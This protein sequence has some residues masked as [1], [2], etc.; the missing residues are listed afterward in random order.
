MRK[1]LKTLYAPLLLLSSFFLLFLI[2]ITYSEI[3]H[4][5]ERTPFKSEAAVQI[6]ESKHF[7][8]TDIKPYLE[9]RGITI[10]FS[11]PCYHENLR[12]KL[13]IFPPVRLN[14]HSNATSQKQK[15]FNI[16][17]EFKAGQNY[18]ISIS[19]DFSCGGLAYL[20]TLNT[21]KMPDK[22][23]GIE[24]IEKGS[25]I[26]K[27]S[28]Q[29]LHLDLVNIDELLF[30]GL[31]IPPILIPLTIDSVSGLSYEKIKATYEERLRT[32]M[33]ILDKGPG[34]KE[35]AGAIIE[36]R[37][38]FFPGME[39][40]T[41]KTFSMPLSF[42][43][44]KERGGI[45]VVSLKSNRAEQHIESPVRI[46]RITDI[47]L[48]YK[49][50]DNSLLIF[51]SSL[52]TGKPLKD[53]SLLALF[54]RS[55]A[56]NLG[57]TDKNGV[58]TL[59]NLNAKKPILLDPNDKTANSPL[60]FNDL[61]FIL[62]I[63]SG[64]SSFIEINP[65][66]HI[67]PDWVTQSH[68]KKAVNRPLKGHVF[69]ERGIYRPGET[70]H[71]KGTIREYK[72][73]AILPPMD[74]KPTIKI[75]DSKG[76]IV[77]EG[78]IELSEFGTAS[79]SLTIKPYFPLGTYTLTM[80]FAG[81]EEGAD[82][83]TASRTFQVQEFQ[84]PRHFTEI[85]FKPERKKDT[86]YINLDRETAFLGCEIGGAYYAGGP[87]KHG[88][89][90]WKIYYNSTD[91][92]KEQYKG[93]TFGNPLE[94]R[95]ELIESGESILDENG[96]IT[97]NVP[98]SKNVV[99]GLY[100]VEVIATVVDFD[101][102]A[103]SEST[104]Y[105]AE[106]GYLVGISSHKG[107][108]KAGDSESLT[109][110]VIDKDGKHL[111]KGKISVEVMK[112][113][114][115]WIR[116]RN[117]FGNVYWGGQELWRKELASTIA[118]EKSNAIFDFDFVNGGDYLLK[119]TYQGGDGKSYTSSTRY[120]VEGYFYGYE[121]ENR[122]RNFER[123][124]VSTEKDEYRPGETIRVLV[125]PHKK[126]SSLLMTIEREGV[127]EHRTIDGVGGRRYI[128]IPVKKDLCTEHLYIIP[129]NYCQRRIPCQ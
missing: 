121:Y 54:G 129:W 40:N 81:N 15:I 7:T 104:V 92:P 29:M 105:Q 87:V 30:Q 50:S 61:R 34:L 76:E 86:R 1:R 123:L 43:K 10:T 23:S 75:V 12:H 71:Y 41:K 99:S 79:G 57:R 115:T 60:S 28:R 108:I 82:K 113:G 117:E 84:P 127:I 114:F 4:A 51:A 103:A 44:E 58:L 97:V 37:Q 83:G 119:F 31:S 32:I 49:I 65:S 116:K 109:V 78:R 14:W 35:F 95:E 98:L 101:G 38:L 47:G 2:S 77:H 22:K 36:E 67:K 90:R 111:E 106:P 56:V 52:N 39:R 25:I 74:I 8:I 64:D 18:S 88:K 59:G 53:V 66:G 19:K 48:T 80:A 26:E 9:N 125:S 120:R 63:S 42:R 100:G 102:K 118:L 110:I 112:K 126:L 128:D 96:K 6:D 45:E 5:Q 17:G 27:N 94:K 69:T 68:G 70:V 13:K 11:E 85:L 107:S 21:F 62:A 72:N 122:E 16:I 46:F 89:V 3:A 33:P 55:A 73:G 91:F 20:Q 93:F 124:S 24:F